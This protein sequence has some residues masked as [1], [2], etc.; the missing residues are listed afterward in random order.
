[1]PEFKYHLSL[2]FSN[3]T[4]SQHKRA[5]FIETALLYYDRFNHFL[6]V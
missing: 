5:V 4:L 6:Q 2:S 1:M 3:T